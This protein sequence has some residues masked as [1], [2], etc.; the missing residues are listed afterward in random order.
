MKSDETHF[1][2]V[3]MLGACKTKYSKHLKNVTEY[4]CTKIIVVTLRLKLSLQKG[5]YKTPL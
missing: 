1:L 3:T 2:R 4:S 5:C